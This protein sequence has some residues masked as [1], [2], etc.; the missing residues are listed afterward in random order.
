MAIHMK[1][2]CTA[3]LH[4]KYPKLPGGDLLIVAGDLTSRDLENEMAL[5]DY[6][7]NEQN[8]AAKIIIGGNH[9]NVLLEKRLKLQFGTYLED[10]ECSFNG[11]K[12]WGS[13]WTKEFPGMNPKCKAFTLKTEEELIEKWALIPDDTNVLITHSPPFSILDGIP[14]FYDGTLFHSG[15]T[16]LLVRIKQL[17]NLK[18]HVFGHIH[19]GFGL[20]G[21]YEMPHMQFVNASQVNRAYKPVNFPIEINL[22]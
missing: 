21:D 4:G 19:E 6:W 14:N 1:I 2:T 16:S 20:C 12:I 15:S 18:L 7:L 9:D 11:F 22:E 3:D 8:Y 13:P 17:K 5:F 10:K